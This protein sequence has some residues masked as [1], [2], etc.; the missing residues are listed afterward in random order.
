MPLKV[1]ER[2]DRAQ[3]EGL[4]ITN[5]YLLQIPTFRANS[6]MK[7]I[8]I[9]IAAILFSISIHAQASLSFCTFVDNQECV[10]ENTKFISTPDSAFVKIYMMVRSLD[11]LSTNKLTFKIEGIDRFGKEVDYKTIEQEIQPDWRSCWQPTLFRS[12]GKY[13]IRVYRY[14]D[15]LLATREM[16]IF[17]K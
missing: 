11:L 16:E 10:F 2:R 1:C 15:K 3:G 6:C 7:K 9:C 5:F 4:D 14:G 13:I 17:D 8:A 12:P